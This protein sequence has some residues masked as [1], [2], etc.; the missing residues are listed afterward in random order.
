MHIFAIRQNLTLSGIQR[1]NENDFVFTST[2]IATG[3][4]I[5]K[6]L[7]VG[8]AKLERDALLGKAKSLGCV[9]D[10]VIHLIRSECSHLRTERDFF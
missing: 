7:F 8:Y 2:A 3:K 4:S 6:C 10:A 1:P 9:L 5:P